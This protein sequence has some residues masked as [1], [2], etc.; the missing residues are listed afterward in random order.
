MKR[1]FSVVTIMLLFQTGMAASGETAKSFFYSFAS[2]ND[3]QD[4]QLDKGW[5]ITDGV[6]RRAGDSIQSCDG[7][8]LGDTNWQNYD[9]AFKARRLAINPKDQHWGIRLRKGGESVQIYT[10][11]E[12]LVALSQE[13][14]SKIGPMFETVLPVGPRANWTQFDFTIRDRKC[15]VKINDRIAAEYN[16]K[17]VSSGNIEIYSY[18][19][20]LEIDDLS[21]R[22]YPPSESATSAVPA[23]PNLV[24]NSGFEECTL[25]NLPDYWGCPHWGIGDLRAISNLD[26]WY[27]DFRTVFDNPWEGKRCMRIHNSRDGRPGSSLILR[28]CNMRS[29][30]GKYK[31][32]AYF[33]SDNP[34]M[35]ISF[36]NQKIIVSREWKRYVVDFTNPGN[37]LYLDMINIMPLDKGTVYIDAVQ[38]EAGETATPWQPASEDRH[39]MVHDGNAEKTMYDVP[40]YAP[41]YRHDKMVLDGRLDE[42][43]W[44]ELPSLPF[45]AQDKTPARLR[46]EGRVWYDDRGLYIGM[47]CYGKPAP[48][49]VKERDGW[50]WQDPSVEVFLDPQLTRSLYYHFVLNRNNV[51]YDGFCQRPSWNGIWQSAT[52]TSPDQTFWSAEVFI[53]FGT[54]GIG[55]GSQATW[56]FNLGREEQG[57]AECWAPTYGGFH[58]PLRFG[59]LTIAP[60]VQREY[61]FRVVESKL[62]RIDAE[63]AMLTVAVANDTNRPATLVVNSEIAGEKLSKTVELAAGESQYAELGRIKLPTQAKPQRLT[64]TMYE[65]DSLRN[66]VE[67]DLTVPELMD[68]QLQ[69]GVTDASMQRL[70][71]LT[72]LPASVAKGAKINT[73]LGGKS[74]SIPLGEDKTIQDLP[75]DTLPIGNNEVKVELSSANGKQLAAKELSFQKIPVVSNGVFI[76]RFSRMITVNGKPFMP[77]GIFCEAMPMPESLPFLADAGFNT[78]VINVDYLYKKIKPDWNY[79]QTVFDAAEKHHL[80]IRAMLSGRDPEFCRQTI[81]RLK[82]HPAL[83]CWDIFDEIFTVPW[84]MKNYE[85][86]VKTVAELK[87]LDPAHPVMINE[88]EWGMNFLTA[89]NLEF[90]GDI[91]SLDHYAHPPQTNLQYYDVLLRTMERLGRK[92]CRPS[93]MYLLGAGYAFHAAR[94]HTPEEHRFIAYSSVINGAT[95]IFYFADIPKSRS[96]YNAIKELLREFAQ[97]SPIIASTEKSR[98]VECSDPE[99]DFTTRT[100][101]QQL[102]ILA[103]N[104][105]PESQSEVKFLLDGVQRAPIEVM[106]EKRELNTENG[107]FADTFSGKQAHVYRVN[108]PASTGQ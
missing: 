107:F 94:D 41:S 67:T 101:G 17:T 20:D 82:D 90:P 5:K 36:N 85:A 68:A 10:Q 45:A 64:V 60:A 55:R 29:K 81:K 31:L 37:N 70:Q 40:E 108:L 65:N 6:L 106:F 50:C 23:S 89:R 76:D 26:Q 91:V 32:S 95:G 71:I 14:H 13:S 42:K 52:Y 12:R 80:K 3:I 92:E 54:L 51:R 39:L 84:G 15:V 104:K 93:W 33:R 86:V 46:T 9:I 7:I 98:K 21:I 4:L 2:S 1:F 30:A 27:N 48:C 53:P 25:D 47:K 22:L 58:N 74:Y 18:G 35:P 88:C 56:G 8:R 77:L 103:V 69:F 59:H 61:L 57:K 63:H 19:V 83:L 73:Y 102:Y 38:L 11:G 78:I 87:Q 16:F 24:L 97:L 62:Q 100:Q 75:I 28:S 66:M 79:I 99:I 44:S 96:A 34:E 72:Q 49:T 43:V 105:S